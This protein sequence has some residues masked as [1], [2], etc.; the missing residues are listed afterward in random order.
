[1]QASAAAARAAAAD[2]QVRTVLFLLATHTEPVGSFGRIVKY[3]RAVARAKAQGTDLVPA[4]VERQIGVLMSAHEAG[5]QLD[6]SALD[7]CY[8]VGRMLHLAETLDVL[9]EV[10]CAIASRTRTDVVPAYRSFRLAD[11]K[12]DEY[13]EWRPV[14]TILT[15]ALLPTH[16]HSGKALDLF[17]RVAIKLMPEAGIMGSR[18]IFLLMIRL[19][20]VHD[21]HGMPRGTPG[22][23]SVVEGHVAIARWICQDPLL[24]FRHH[25][26]LPQLAWELPTAHEFLAPFLDAIFRSPVMLDARVVAE[27]RERM[28]EE[29]LALFDQYVA[30]HL[31][32]SRAAAAAGDLPNAQKVIVRAFAEANLDQAERR[33]PPEIVGKVFAH[34]YH[35]ET[36]TVVKEG[37]ATGTTPFAQL[38]TREAR[39]AVFGADLERQAHDDVIGAF[40]VTDE[41]QTRALQQ[42]RQVSRWERTVRAREPD[43]DN[44]ENVYGYADDAG[45]NDGDADADMDMDGLEQQAANLRVS[46]PQTKRGRVSG[47]AATALA[48]QFDW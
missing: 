12:V 28:P 26:A 29:R 34:L 44:D 15:L 30:M 25:F 1:M 17:K 33:L 14:A 3:I 21:T 2:K 24:I 4:T 38:L 39:N 23:A 7:H 16:P 19:A 48:Q 32:D 31:P 11:I 36:P 6:V 18:L 20:R 10:G 42:P 35:D 27:W 9:K 22:H 13:V 43:D 5:N 40:R 47:R 37:A 46:A 41:Q 8:Q 45:A